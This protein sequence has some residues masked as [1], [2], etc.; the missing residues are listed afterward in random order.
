MKAKEDVD[1]PEII[2]GIFSF[3]GNNIYA[4]IDPGSTHSYIC[5][6][7]IEGL[8]LEIEYSERNVLVMH[9][10]GQS[11]VMNK[12]IMNCPLPIAEHEFFADLWLLSFHEFDAILGFNWLSSH[13]PWL[14]VELEVYA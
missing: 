12:L 4:L 10:L 6:K 13:K 11:I 8:C 1:L 7:V 3:L 5:T 2:T 14:I 9:P